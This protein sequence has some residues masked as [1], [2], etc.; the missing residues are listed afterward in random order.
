MKR[1]HAERLLR[2]ADHLDTVPVAE[3]DYAHFISECGTSACA[4]GH[5]AR[6][7][8]FNVLG[9][10]IRRLHGKN[11]VVFLYEDDDDEGCENRHNEAIRYIF[12]R[13]DG[14]VKIF[15]PLRTEYNMTASQVASKFRAFVATQ[16]LT[17]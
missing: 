1:I 10:S 16:E 8:E 3:F 15:Y 5:A 17:D 14:T 4:L 13:E 2:L 11:E 9:L 7:P 6:L 12:G